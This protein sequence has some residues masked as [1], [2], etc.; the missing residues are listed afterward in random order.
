MPVGSFCACSPKAF[1]PRSSGRESFHLQ[2][3]WG[4]CHRNGSLEPDPGLDDQIVKGKEKDGHESDDGKGQV[5]AEP[6][7]GTLGL[8]L[9]VSVGGVVVWLDRDEV[10]GA[11]F[12]AAEWFLALHYQLLCGAIIRFAS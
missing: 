11:F 3:A 6:G 7:F 8:F 9:A 1:V 4:S 12:S 10:V 2:R 5:K